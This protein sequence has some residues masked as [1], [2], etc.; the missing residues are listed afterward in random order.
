MAKRKS[1]MKSGLVDMP[2]QT[3]TNVVVKRIYNRGR[4]KVVDGTSTSMIE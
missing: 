4:Y 1:N 3:R 2:H